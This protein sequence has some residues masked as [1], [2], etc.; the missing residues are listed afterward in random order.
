MNKKLEKLNE[1]FFKYQCAIN[2]R[3]K[4]L[5]EPLY[6]LGVSHFGYM[7][8]FNDGSYYTLGDD[9]NLVKAYL[10][11]VC[12][13]VFFFKAETL[14][15]LSTIYRYSLLPYDMEVFK[16]RFEGKKDHVIKLLYDFNSYNFVIYRTN[17]EGVFECYNFGVKKH[18]ISDTSI[19][20]FYLT[21]L[22]CF[23]HFMDYFSEKTV[24]FNYTKIQSNRAYYEMWYAMPD[25]SQ[26]EQVTEKIKH[27]FTEAVINRTYI[28]GRN[29]KIKLS[30]R[31]AECVKYLS[32]GYR[33]KG[34]ANLLDLSP[35]TIEYYLSNI[36]QKTGQS[37]RIQLIQSF[38]GN[39]KT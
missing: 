2:A 4:A 31:Q 26:D 14:N 6:K 12:E 30:P 21:Y 25:L 7:D 36:K 22:P 29:K 20:Q 3:I 10:I 1:N 34:I 35:R 37:S 32:E 13:P 39:N 16:R 18:N 9:L 11:T 38:I 28:E 27:F 8:L 19:S 33:V 5:C 15:N 17:N 23:K 24:E